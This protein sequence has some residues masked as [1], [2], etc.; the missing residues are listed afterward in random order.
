MSLDG[1]EGSKVRN[2]IETNHFKPVGIANKPGAAGTGMWAGDGLDA[3]KLDS[4]AKALQVLANP[5]KAVP[6]SK[7]TLDHVWLWVESET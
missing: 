6:G 4:V 1:D 3:T 7:A 2:H 5:S